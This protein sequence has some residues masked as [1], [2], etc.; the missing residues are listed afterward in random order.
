M[1]PASIAR[2]D[3]VARKA[4]SRQQ[5]RYLSVAFFTSFL[6]SL[7]A[8]RASFFA[9]RTFRFAWRFVFSAPLSVFSA[10]FALSVTLA[11]LSLMSFAVSL[12][13]SAGSARPMATAA[14]IP[15]SIR[16]PFFAKPAA[17]PG[18]LREAAHA[19]FAAQRPG[20][21]LPLPAGYRSFGWPLGEEAGSLLS[22]G[23][24][25]SVG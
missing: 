2:A 8:C 11:A 5:T 10:S 9:L 16:F 23:F 25:V 15:F 12:S 18:V 3:G 4:L 22:V 14:M 7:F 1:P 24:V 20:E 6:T 13:A 21:R 19:T 17:W